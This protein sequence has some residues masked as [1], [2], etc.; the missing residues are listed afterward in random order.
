MI[1]KLVEK[2]KDGSDDV[3]DNKIVWL[4]ALRTLAAGTEEKNMEQKRDKSHL[5][6]SPL[7]TITLLPGF[8]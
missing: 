1:M 5:S 4:P 3:Y 6:S 7:V 2:E 8:A